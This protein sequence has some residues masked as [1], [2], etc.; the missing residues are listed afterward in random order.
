MGNTHN[1][2]VTEEDYV[3]GIRRPEFRGAGAPLAPLDPPLIQLLKRGDNTFISNYRPVSVLP[4]FSKILGKIVY[5]RL[6]GF[7]NQ[8]QILYFV[9]VYRKT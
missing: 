6:M 2:R 3:I 9:W 1:P 5:N 8:N 4:L 7:I